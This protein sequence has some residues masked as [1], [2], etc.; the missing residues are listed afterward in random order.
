MRDESRQMILEFLGELL[1]RIDAGLY[2]KFQAYPSILTFHV[3]T[4]LFDIIVIFLG[5]LIHLTVSSSLVIVP[6][7]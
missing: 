4:V 3:R 6:L 5:H 2:M 7:Y 1:Q